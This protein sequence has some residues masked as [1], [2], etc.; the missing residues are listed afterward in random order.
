MPKFENAIRGKSRERPLRLLY[1]TGLAP[2]IVSANDHPSEK[3]QWLRLT[4]CV[5]IS[6]PE[7]RFLFKPRKDS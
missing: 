2:Q 3:V 4:R 5:S 6:I 7:Q 1:Q